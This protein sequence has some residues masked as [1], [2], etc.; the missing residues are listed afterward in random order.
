MLA[1]INDRTAVLRVLLDRGAD[2]NARTRAGWTALT[3]A[4]WRGHAEAV[5]LL[6]ARGADPNVT[7]REGWTILQY[8][9]W[10]ATDPIATDDLPGPPPDVMKRAPSPGPAHAEVVSLLKQARVRR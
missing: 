8:A 1:A 10:R 2:V 9:S 3:Y 6:L 4:A 5:R 7:D